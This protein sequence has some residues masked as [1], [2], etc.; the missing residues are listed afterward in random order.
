E[1]VLH[2]DGKGFAPFYDIIATL[3]H[4]TNSQLEVPGIGLQ[5]QYNPGTIVGLCGKVLAH[6]V[7][8]VDSDGDRFCLVQYFHR[9][10]LEFISQK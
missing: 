9:K 5:F 4:Y 2:C 1:T 7:G 8:E 10:V 3:G 6:S